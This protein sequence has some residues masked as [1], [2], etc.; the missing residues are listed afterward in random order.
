MNGKI[1]RHD[2]DHHTHITLDAAS[3]DQIEKLGWYAQEMLSRQDQGR[4]EK[5]SGPDFLPRLVGGAVIL[6][7]LGRERKNA[8]LLED[9]SAHLAFMTCCAVAITAKKLD[10]DMRDVLKRT[11]KLLAQCC[12]VEMTIPPLPPLKTLPKRYQANEVIRRQYKL[13]SNTTPVTGDVML[14][15]APALLW[16]F[17]KAD[18]PGD[19]KVLHDLIEATEGFLTALRRISAKP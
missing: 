17:Q 13:W 19:A 11:L 15:D 8:F 12:P 14:S 5:V 10:A 1:Q 6:R 18:R 16:I 7:R 9:D 3:A 4:W 2:G